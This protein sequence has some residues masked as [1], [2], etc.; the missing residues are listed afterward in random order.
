[1]NVSN[2]LYFPETVIFAEREMFGKMKEKTTQSNNTRYNTSSAASLHAPSFGYLLS[3]IP[4]KYMTAEILRIREKRK[5]V[6]L[7]R[8]TDQQLITLNL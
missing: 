7:K 3:D 4:E 6:L 1:M 2:K 5:I 8:D